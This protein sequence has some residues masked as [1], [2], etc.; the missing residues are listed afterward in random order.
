MSRSR[1]VLL[2]VS[3]LLIIGGISAMMLWNKPHRTAE[4]EE[5][6]AISA[7]SLITAYAGNEKAADAK[8]LNQT[9][10]VRGM[11]VKVEKNQD[12]QTTV[13]Y[14]SADP[15]SSVFCTLRDKGASIDSGR[16]ATLKGFC[17]GHTTDV[18]L[19]DCIVVP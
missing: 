1:I 6:I 5:G 4:A 11:V 19:T 13:L 17:S 14:A 8:Y 12:G 2:I 10:A 16:I 7:D 18:L 15:L 3:I 9:I